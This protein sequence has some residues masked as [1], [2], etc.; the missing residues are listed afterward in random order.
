MIPVVFDLDGTLIDSL[1]DITRA[2]NALL[3]DE[4]LPPLSQATVGGFVGLGE[5]VFMERLIEATALLPRDYDRLMPPF[6]EHYKA[7][8]AGT[9]LFPGAREAL[10]RLRDLGAPLALCTNKPSAPLAPTLKAAGLVDVFDVIV[11]GDTLPVR[12]PDPAVLRHVVEAL[13]SCGCVYVGDSE[14]DAQTAA[15]ACVPF[16]LYTDGIRQSPVEA[17][18]HDAAFS[19]FRDLPGIYRAVA[20]RAETVQPFG[21]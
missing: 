19:D 4:G 16:I 6:I 9:R 18:P 21:A 1:P 5:R 7:A 8:T 3:A 20:G 17:I 2:A 12:K 15:N 11:A 10:R 14:T 13:G